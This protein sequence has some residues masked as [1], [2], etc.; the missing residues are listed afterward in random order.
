MAVIIEHDT[1]TDMPRSANGK[2]NAVEYAKCIYN[3]FSAHDNRFSYTE[4]DDYIVV[5]NAFKIYFIKSGWD[6]MGWKIVNL[7]DESLLQKRTNGMGGTNNVAVYNA[8]IISSPGFFYAMIYNPS[9]KP[10][11]TM[12]FW[13]TKNNKNYIG[14]PQDGVGGWST[15]I[16]AGA[17]TCIEE[18]DA[19]CKIPTPT[20]Y[21]LTSPKLMFSDIQFVYG[22]T[23]T[24]SIIDEL[25]V[26][27]YVQYMSTVSTGGKNYYAI[28]NNSLIEV[29]TS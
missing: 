27:S 25:K 6:Q 23:G 12:F 15:P 16:E 1:I 17:I 26:C 13:H 4:D 18:S 22:N 3:L 24:Y 19:T 9:N 14:I 10:Q 8:D 2:A 11:G 28:G 29:T 5:N 7:N 21:G 20:V